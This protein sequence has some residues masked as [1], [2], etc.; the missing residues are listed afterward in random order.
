MPLPSTIALFPGPPPDNGSN[1]TTEPWFGV[2]VSARRLL[3]RFRA[4]LLVVRWAVI[5]SMPMM[6]TETKDDVIVI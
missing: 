2:D 1:E 6:C 4:M 3:I 5:S